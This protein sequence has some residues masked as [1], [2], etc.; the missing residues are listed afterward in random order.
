MAVDVGNCKETMTENDMIL[1]GALLEKVAWFEYLREEGVD[2][3]PFRELMLKTLNTEEWPQ[4]NEFWKA[5]QELDDKPGSWAENYGNSVKM[6]ISKYGPPGWNPNTCKVNWKEYACFCNGG[7]RIHLQLRDVDMHP[8]KKDKILNQ[9]FS[10]FDGS[11]EVMPFDCS[12][13]TLSDDVYDKLNAGPIKDN[14][15]SDADRKKYILLASI[16]GLTVVGV[17][18]WGFWPKDE[19]AI[20]EQQYRL[21]RGY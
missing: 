5:I 11:K 8:E 19:E 4:E 3:V 12:Q 14:K 2:L 21:A 16:L 9:Y 18:V 6:F 7:A 10:Q 20:A 17:A 1:L 15:V 13:A